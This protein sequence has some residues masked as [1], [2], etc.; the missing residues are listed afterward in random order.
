MTAPELSKVLSDPTKG[1]VDLVAGLVPDSGA[2]A[3]RQ[4]G[5]G[6]GTTQPNPTATPDAEPGRLLLAARQCRTAVANAPTDDLARL[7]MESVVTP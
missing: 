5:T 6:G 1:L 2:R 7:L 4:N 3:R